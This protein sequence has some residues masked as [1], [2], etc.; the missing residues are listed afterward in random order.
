MKVCIICKI[1][2]ENNLF[3]KQRKVCKKCRNEQR[4]INFQN[5]LD[6]K[7][8]KCGFI[9]SSSHFEFCKNICKNCANKFK[10]DRI[11]KKIIEIENNPNELKQCFKCKKEII[12]K[13][14]QI[15]TRYCKQCWN[16]H[17]ADK[18]K[19]NDKVKITKKCIKCNLIAGKR[20]FIV[21]K[22]ICKKCQSKIN[23]NALKKNPAR[24]LMV[25][26]KSA[27]FS[28]L[29]E[30]RH[31]KYVL[32]YISYTMKE[33]KQH[34][35]NQFEYWMTWENHGKYNTKMWDDNDQS[36]WT[37]NIDHIVPQSHLPYDSVDH[38]NFKKCWAL[39]NLRPYSAKQNIIDGNRR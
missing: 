35:E 4:I 30:G 20:K 32:K 7:C 37:W 11:N 36:T 31:G 28:Q 14:F 10:Q 17:C 13:N 5:R 22:N 2:K 27:I 33:L 16:K 23:Y 24:F 21:G 29:I 26:I 19:K 12:I 15:N 9:G 25:R 38:P 8:S 3:E 1:N 6:I 18:I 39:E 34:L